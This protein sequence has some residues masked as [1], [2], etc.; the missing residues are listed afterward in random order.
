MK[1]NLI[2]NEK[3]NNIDNN[4]IANEEQLFREIK[5]MLY[6]KYLNLFFSIFRLFLMFY[7]LSLLGYLSFF[8][9][10]TNFYI[11]LVLFSV[12]IMPIY[13]I[14]NLIIV[15]AGII[16]RN[17]IQNK[18]DSIIDC[19]CCCCGC[20]C[21]KNVTTL[22]ML[23]LI[24]GIISLL[25]SFYLLNFFLI[26]VKTEN[27]IKYFPNIIKNVSIKLILYFIDS[28]LLLCQAYFFYYHEYFLKRGKIFI[29]FYKRL[30]IKNRNKEADLVRDELPANIDNLLI[31]SETEMSNI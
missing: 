15:I 3:N 5:K 27:N 23:A 8:G 22:K 18:Q 12:L 2:T 7:S 13:T 1:E 19:I 31:N 25:R 9:G 24:Y 21:T 14:I 29:E 26:Y 17:F 11:I 6:I 4:S 10:P 30:I 20:L 16:G 28:I